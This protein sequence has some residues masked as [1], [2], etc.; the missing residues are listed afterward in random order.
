MHYLRTEYWLNFRKEV[1]ELRKVCEIC[2]STKNLNVHHRHYKSVGKETLEDVYLLCQS[3][4]KKLHKV[5]KEK[6]ISYDNAF[7]FLKKDKKPK[8]QRYAELQ[9]K[10]TEFNKKMLEY[11]T[12]GLKT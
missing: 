12:V 1:R 7:K 8:G 9:R 5:A 10:E 11:R 4:H 6:K 2:G 3:H